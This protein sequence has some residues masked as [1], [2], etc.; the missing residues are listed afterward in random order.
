M[1]IEFLKIGDLFFVH[2]I[3]NCNSIKSIDV[4]TKIAVYNASCVNV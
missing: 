3:V 2:A 1:I 4:T